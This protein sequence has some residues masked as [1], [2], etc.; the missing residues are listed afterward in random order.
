MNRWLLILLWLLLLSCSSQRQ[1]IRHHTTEQSALHHI[2]TDSVHS[3]DWHHE[4]AWQ[5]R[6]GRQQVLILPKGDFKYSVDSGF[7]GSA[8]YVW[9]DQ[10]SAEA[11]SFGMSDSSGHTS[12][13]QGKFAQVEIRDSTTEQL[14]AQKKA[15][16]LRLPS[17]WKTALFIAL[18]LSVLWLLR[19]VRQH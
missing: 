5:L 1:R 4:Q 10:I 6:A 16:E 8:H 19:R 11:S 14:H 7:V 13:Y 12:V 9:M 2:R 3:A 17:G 15:L 18:V